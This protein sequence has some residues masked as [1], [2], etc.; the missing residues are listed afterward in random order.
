[1]AK[2]NH[3]RQAEMNTILKMLLNCNSDNDIIDILKIPRST[4]YRYKAEIYQQYSELFQAAT[5]V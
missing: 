4:Y 1:M 2:A 5:N 3:L